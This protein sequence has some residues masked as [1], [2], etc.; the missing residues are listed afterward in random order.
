MEHLLLCFYIN[1]HARPE[2]HGEVVRENGDFFNQPSDEAF[3]ELGDLGGL[4]GDEILQFLDAFQIFLLCFCVHL[5]LLL[6][7]AKP[8]DL[9][10]D[11]VVVL[12]AVRFIDELFL[13]LLEAFVEAFR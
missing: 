11:G 12:F 7:V 4:V 1:R 6:L 13:Q 9:V 3:V 8:E 10:G 5:G 2:F